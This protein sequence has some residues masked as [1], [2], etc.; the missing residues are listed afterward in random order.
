MDCTMVAADP[1]H[2]IGYVEPDCWQADDS[3]GIPLGL[4]A[5]TDTQHFIRLQLNTLETPFSP[6][7]GPS[8]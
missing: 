3:G 6:L 2:P 8:Q 4:S 5:D 1:V 7:T